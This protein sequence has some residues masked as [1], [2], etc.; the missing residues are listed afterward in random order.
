MEKNYYEVGGNQTPA[1]PVT[2][3]NRVSVGYLFLEF[4][5]L[6]KNGL[7]GPNK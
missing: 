6:V 7:F 4:D 1:S 3:L 2:R 5:P